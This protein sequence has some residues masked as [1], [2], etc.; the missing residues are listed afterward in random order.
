[1]AYAIQWKLDTT[2]DTAFAEGNEHEKPNKGHFALKILLN[3]S[4]NSSKSE[5]SA[6]FLKV[7]WNAAGQAAGCRRQNERE[8]SK[9]SPNLRVGLP[10][11]SR[12]GSLREQYFKSLNLL[13][14]RFRF[15]P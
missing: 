15:N 7:I 13:S 2:G 8:K 11:F 1:M 5:D 3:T 14:T 6:L 4:H 9:T 10:K 12:L